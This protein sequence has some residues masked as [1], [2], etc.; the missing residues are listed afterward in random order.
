MESIG[1]NA[2]IE[3]EKTKRVLSSLLKNLGI[4]LYLADAADDIS[5]DIKKGNYNPLTKNGA[6]Y[7]EN[8][9]LAKEVMTY[10][11]VQASKARDLLPLKDAGEFIDNIIYLSL[12]ASTD[13]IYSKLNSN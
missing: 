5:D 6:P 11:L 2:P 9:E 8:I 13:R 12:P 10:S 7:K 4:W 1:Q 3:D